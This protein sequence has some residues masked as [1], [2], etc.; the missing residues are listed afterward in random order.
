[1]A[2]AV[3]WLVALVVGAAGCGVKAPPLARSTLAPPAVKHIK[4]EVVAKGV[5]ISF[6]IPRAERPSQA[7]VGLRLYY[8]YADPNKFSRCTRCTPRLTHYRWLA[9][10]GGKGLMQGGSFAYLDE[11]IP[12]GKM[13]LYQ[14]VLRDRAGRW[15]R[16]SVV[17]RV[18]R[19]ALAAAPKWLKATGGDGQVTL[20][21]A[22]VCTLS[23]GQPATDIAGYRLWRKDPSGK[24]KMLA[25]LVKAT[26]M[27]DATVTNGRSYA[28][29]VAAVRKVD[30]RLL[31]G[32][33]TG[34]VSATPRD[35]TPPSAPTDLAGVCHKGRVY[36]RFNPCPEQD[37]AGYLIWRSRPGGKW[38]LLTPKPIGENTYV[39]T[40]PRPGRYTYCVQAVDTAGN[41][42]PKSKPLVINCRE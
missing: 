14:V 39:D 8:A 2:R 23:T 11:D 42:G 3:A 17:V 38:K 33:V 31:P 12:I 6:A 21:W 5:R 1:M 22:E 18:V 30:G 29:K 24:I 26:T 28:Y 16:P 36:L 10:A 9:I 32:L 25:A 20:A 15:G 40:L 7:I 41:K 35:M 37:V 19:R 27:V 34:W 13:G 4:A